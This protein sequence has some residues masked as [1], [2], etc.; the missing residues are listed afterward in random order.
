MHFVF[1]SVDKTLTDRQKRAAELKKRT[2]RAA[3]MNDSEVAEL[4][5]DIKVSLSCPTSAP[6]Y[7]ALSYKGEVDARAHHKC[8]FLN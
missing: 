7:L 2:E 3:A 8:H 1:V 5:H 4:R 6:S